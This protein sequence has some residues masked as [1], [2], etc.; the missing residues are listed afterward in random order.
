MSENV[1]ISKQ[2]WSVSANLTL[3]TPGSEISRNSRLRIYYQERKYHI[4]LGLLLGGGSS[5]EVEINLEPLVNGGMHG[6]VLVADLLRRQPLLERL[7]LRRRA[8][9]VRPAQIQDIPASQPTVPEDEMQSIQSRMRWDS[10]YIT[11]KAFFFSKN[12][13]LMTKHVL[14][15]C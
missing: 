12:I 14:P 11:Q 10:D 7:V 4:L 15:T 2:S 13:F 8:V 3:D 9:L 5:E 6:M 1:P